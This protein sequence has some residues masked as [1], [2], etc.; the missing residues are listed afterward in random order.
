MKI[1]LKDIQNQPD[2]RN[3]DIDK[4]GVKEIHYPIVVLDKKNKFQH[5]IASVNMYVDL[6]H[7]FKGTHMSRF[8]EI[9]N[10]YHGEI[11]VKNF[12]VILKNMK[13]RFDA[14]T[15]HL[16]VEFP[17]FIEKKAPVSRAKG[18]MEYRCRFSGSL[19]EKKDFILEVIVPVTTLCP[20]SK[21]ISKRGAHNQR[22]MVKV[23]VR[24]KNFVWIE[25]I[26]DIV[27]KSASSP[28]YSI[29]KRYDEKYVTEHAYNNPKFVEDVVRDVAAK[30]NEL[31]E[32][33]YFT[34]EAENW[35][36]IHNHNAYACLE[37][38]TKTSIPQ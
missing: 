26:I 21:E 36:S 16:E 32:V 7:H 11:T 30:L 5:T 2:Y 22:G 1:K 28:V 6:P 10:E 15:A 33:T 23:R 38:Q 4:V 17:Y 20:C 3:I 14:R 13:K 27:E 37:K 29:L 12:P 25:D 19:G 18:I 31:N 24:F 8:I 34:V 9:L 35:E